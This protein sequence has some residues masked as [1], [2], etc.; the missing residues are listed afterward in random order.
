MS[1]E[2]IT[3]IADEGASPSSSQWKYR[4]KCPS[5]SQELAKLKMTGFDRK[6]F[7]FALL[8]VGHQEPLVR[9]DDAII[10]EE[11]GAFLPSDAIGVIVK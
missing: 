4:R 11:I 10:C 1:G 3:I 2:D 9:D 8:L 6:V 5:P 7:V